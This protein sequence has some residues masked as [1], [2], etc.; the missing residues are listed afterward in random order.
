MEVV[1]RTAIDTGRN[2][3]SIFLLHEIQASYGVARRRA[4]KRTPRSA[5]PCRSPGRGNP[6]TVQF[7]TA[8]DAGA[9]I[10]HEPSP[11]STIPFPPHRLH[12]APVLLAGPTVSPSQACRKM[13]LCTLW[14][15]LRLHRALRPMCMARSVSSRRSDADCN[16]LTSGCRPTN[17]LSLRATEHSEK[18][19][20]ELST[21]AETY[22]RGD[23][24]R[25]VH[26]CLAA[27]AVHLSWVP[28]VST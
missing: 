2:S 15:Q 21:C 14:R 27:F 7:L 25:C 4:R 12:T 16:L 11:S 23:A 9:S 6:G 22:G 19:V 18:E 28:S 20:H 24:C 3:W 17:A 8:T 13:K 5:T 26:W 10:L 1:V